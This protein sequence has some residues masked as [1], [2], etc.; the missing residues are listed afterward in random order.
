MKRDTRRGLRVVL[1]VLHILIQILLLWIVISKLGSR[2]G[3]NTEQILINLQ[4]MF[5]HYI[6]MVG[7]FCVYYT[8]M[9]LIARRNI[10][11]NKS[12]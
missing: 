9:A 7:A 10:S 6:I 12:K 11:Q 3:Q 4:G 1:S 5:T 2:R 8:S